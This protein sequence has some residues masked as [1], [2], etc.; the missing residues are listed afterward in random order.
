MTGST[1]YPQLHT[2][3]DTAAWLLSG[4]LAISL[5]DLGSRTDQSSLTCLGMSFGVTSLLELVHVA[6]TV[7]W[8]GGIGTFVQLHDW[9]RP[10]TWPP[11]ACVLPIGAICSIWLARGT[12]RQA[13]TMASMLMLLGVALLALFYFLP[14][15]SL[16]NSLGISR[17][18]LLIVPPLWVV[19]GVICWQQRARNRIYTALAGLAALLCLGQ[20][21]MLYSRAPHDAPAM[22]AHFSKLCG[23]LTL[24]LA[25]MRLATVDA[26]ERARSEEALAHSNAT[27]EEGVRLRTAELQAA[28]TNLKFEVAT[29]R[30]AELALADSHLRTRAI[31]ET[32]LDGVITMDHTGRIAEFNSAAERIFGYERNTVI[33]QPL[34]EKVI[35]VALRE[36]HQRGLARYL[37]SHISS[38]LGKRVELTGLRADGTTVPIELSINR[39][40][41]AGPPLFAAFI[42]DITERRAATEAIQ[43]SQA[44]LQTLTESLP[45]LV[46]TCLPNLQCDFLSRQWVEYTGRPESEQLGYGWAD[47]VHPEDREQAQARWSEAGG[48]GVAFDTEF[49]IRRNDGVYRWFTA[50]AIPFHDAAGQIVKWFGSNTD[51]DDLK[52][53][54]EKLRTQLGRMNLLD[55][56]TR[57]VGNRQDLPSIFRVVL[58]SLEDHLPIDFGCMCLR[59]SQQATLTV[60]CVGPRSQE[61][62]AGMNLPEQTQIEI[63]GNGLGRCMDGKFVYEPDIGVSPFDFP[64]RLARGGMR[65]LLIAPL[66]VESHVFGVMVA[67]RLGVAS[68]SSAECEFLRQLSEH[69]ALAAHQAQLYASL[70]NAFEELRRTQHVVL[71][72]E[73]LR[74]V[75]EMASGIAHDINNA[76]SPA[77]LYVQSLLEQETSLSL[78]VRSNLGVIQ[79]SIDDV[80]RTI[81]RMREFSRPRE[82]TIALAPVNLNEVLQQVGEV[83]RARWRDMPQMNGIVIRMDTDFA[84]TLPNVMGA[85]SEIRDACTNLVLNAADA[86][87]A[88]GVITLRSR[89][90]SAVRLP[91]RRSGPMQVQVEVCDTGVGMSEATRNRCLEPFFS[92]KGERGTGLGLAMVYGM[93]QRHG[94]TLEVLSE[95]GDGTTM[96]ITFPLGQVSAPVPR[97]TQR[98]LAPLRILFVDDDLVLLQSLHKTFQRDGHTVV[99]ANGGQSG[100]DTFAAAQENGERFDVVV[101]DLGMPYVDGRT[102]AAAIKEMSSATPVILLTGWGYR[103]IAEHEIPEHVDR[104]L[105]KPPNLVELRVAIA[106]LTR[107][108]TPQPSKQLTS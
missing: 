76:L 17:P 71:Q 21:A 73:R 99:A 82:Q 26:F 4:M 55:Q 68:F 92:T 101:S 90:I 3:L 19:V 96:R 88:G 12:H 51:C 79:R 81:A 57:A 18:T 40:P 98:P 67:A 97:N 85:E 74:A 25:M 102:V 62:V 1:A 15:Y 69:V 37:D 42:R 28:N 39:M 45:H 2:V 11:A 22:V 52:R 89:V 56:T 47:A 35:P 86:L 41:G 49:R 104:V 61:L 107:A 30:E 54:E 100:I 65:S 48:L 72:H 24:Q 36:A 108:P 46:W 60:T 103:L 87:P 64:A 91:G 7:E 5:W 44:R 27:L 59:E 34:T 23:Y 84:A 75:G 29:R 78:E 33:G 58:G 95:L 9:L 43:E 94:A 106:E 31:F 70:Q 10:S 13:L 50:R 77:A 93:V 66:I 53:S 32:A 38:V 63:D 6:T 8:S 105:S 83:T 80:A 16:P 14:R 20:I